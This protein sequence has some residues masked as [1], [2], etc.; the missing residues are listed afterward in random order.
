V[1]RLRVWR[2]DLHVHTVLSPCATYRMAP[3][4]IARRA[5]EVGL[6]VIAI[7]DHNSAEN[8]AAVVEAGRRV[9]LTVLPGLEIE[10]SEEVH[11]LALFEE[12]SQAI[13][14]QSI[15]YSHLPDLPNDEAVY[16][17]QLVVDADDQFV[18]RETRRLLVA[19]S[20]NLSDTFNLA[21]AL[22]GISIPAHVDRSAYGL[23]GVL[24]FV[25]H[26]P[27]FPALEVS[28]HARAHDYAQPGRAA[29][30]SS[31]AHDLDD[32]GRAATDF[33][34]AQPTLAEIVLAC[35]GEE[36]RRVEVI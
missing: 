14:M 32:L 2:A 10:T 24:G 8:T 4:P 27:G 17:A 3:G 13:D 20:L 5:L 33:V 21:S 7:T 23:V 31:D 15:V 34:V 22:G 1:P 19:T 25:P 6:D 29:I 11:V 12:V 16:G 35:R 18:R 26:Q 30:R 9:G 36:S 28:R